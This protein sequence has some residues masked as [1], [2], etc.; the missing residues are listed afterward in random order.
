MKLCIRSAT[1]GCEC[2]SCKPSFFVYCSMRL[3]IISGTK[4]HPKA[5]GFMCPGCDEEHCIWPKG[6]RSEGGGWDFNMNYDRPTFSPSIKI[7][8]ERYEGGWKNWKPG[9]PHW[10]FVCHSHIEDG[11]IKYCEDCTHALSGVVV[12]LPD[13][14]EETELEK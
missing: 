4:E 14:P 12:D 1:S 13:Y 6:A 7:W 9:D 5:L 8:G 11:Q 2:E 10:P 3:R